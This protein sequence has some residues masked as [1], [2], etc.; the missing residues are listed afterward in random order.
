MNEAA[1][2]RT[3]RRRPGHR[4]TVRD[5][6]EAAGVSMM[7]VS[8]VIHDRANVSEQLRLHVRRKIEELNYVPNRA[9][10]ELAGLVR[11][12]VGLLY[13]GVINP[14][15]AAVIVGAMKAAARLHVDVSVQLAQIDDRK[16]LKAT[17]K[18][19]ETAGIDGFLLPSPIAEFVAGH[20]GKLPISVPAVALAP[21]HPLPGIAAVRCDERQAARDL[22][23]LLI[24]AGHRRIGHIAGPDQQSGSAARLQGYEAALR[25]HGLA[26]DDACVVRSAAFR[27]QSG[28]AAAEELLSRRP[29]V[30]AVFAAND[31]LAAAVVAA[32]QRRGMQV[33]AALSV[34]GYDDSPVA[35]QV[36]PGLTT[37][38]QDAE[39]MTE[40]AMEILVAGIRAWRKDPSVRLSSDTVL[41]YR[42]VTRASVAP[43][44]RAGTGGRVP[45]AA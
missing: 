42:I 35:E 45:P 27:F 29:A 44:P 30:T 26:P 14:F 3:R 25:E 31:T 2:K 11:P 4:V 39:A 8:N 12:H 40:R 41:P 37:V 22:V 5:V 17:L 38:H 43:P 24:A 6:A 36:W 21:G 9:A 32:A 20:R 33:P 15:I 10:Q 13:P 1:G 23:S 34:V 16:D 19:M 28:L 18:R 7:T